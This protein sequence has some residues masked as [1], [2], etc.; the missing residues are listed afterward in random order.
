MHVLGCTRS[1][2]LAVWQIINSWAAAHANIGPGG[3][4]GMGKNYLGRSMG[5]HLGTAR[6]MYYV[7][8]QQDEK[9]A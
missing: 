2:L 8:M 1:P 7:K 5:E 3:A 4:D 9:G 6:Y